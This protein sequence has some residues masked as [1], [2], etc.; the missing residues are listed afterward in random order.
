MLPMSGDHHKRRLSSIRLQLRQIIPRYLSDS[1]ETIVT[2]FIRELCGV[3]RSV[4]LEEH[5]LER[6]RNERV[7][8]VEEQRDCGAAERTENLPDEGDLSEV[9]VCFMTL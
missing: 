3:A 6:R 8:F 2:R 4:P 1:I 5:G 7:P 9:H